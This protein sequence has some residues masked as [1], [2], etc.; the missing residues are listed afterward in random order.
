MSGGTTGYPEYRIASRLAGVRSQSRPV[1]V[2]PGNREDRLRAPDT[3]CGDCDPGGWWGV[4][5]EGV[6]MG[7]VTSESIPCDNASEAIH[8]RRR[9]RSDQD[10]PSGGGMESCGDSDRFYCTCPHGP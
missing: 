4:R 3:E 7:V 9:R 5:G 1:H 10:Q 6:K 8:F 2:A